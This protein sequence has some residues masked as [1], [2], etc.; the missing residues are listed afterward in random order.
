VVSVAEGEFREAMRRLAA[1]VNVVTIR[2]GDGV[3]GMTATAVSSLSSDPPS[4]LV[5]VNQAASMHDS[6]GKSRQFCV[7]ILHRDQIDIARTFADRSMRDARFATGGWV[8][9]GDTPPYL[10]DAQAVL[11]CDR[12]QLIAF[13]THSICIGLVRNVR[14]RSDIHPLLYVDGRFSEVMEAA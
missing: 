3:M 8:R 1:T 14:L 10:P 2:T 9:D 6:I 13:G 7:N 5:C 11:F 4:L 12:G